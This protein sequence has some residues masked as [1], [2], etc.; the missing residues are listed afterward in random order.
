MDQ[1]R[2]AVTHMFHLQGIDKIAS[3]FPYGIYTIPEV[4]MVGMTEKEAI[5]KGFEALTGKAKYQDMPRGKILGATDG[6]LKLVFDKKTLVVLGV[7]IIGNLATEIIHYGMTLVE[8]K[9]TLDELTYVVFNYPTL[10]DLYKYAA[11][12]G[13]GNASGHK[14]K[15]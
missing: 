7:H 5:D 15:S 6:F 13:L 8:R 10:H 12:D 3:L 2:A 1:G 14:V 4:S 9:V 11:Y